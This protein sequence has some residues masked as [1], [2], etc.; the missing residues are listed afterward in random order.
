MPFERPLEVE[1][2]L[3]EAR[4]VKAVENWR[5]PRAMCWDHNKGTVSSGLVP[6]NRIR[7]DPERE[8]PSVARGFP[9][10]RLRNNVA[11]V[12]VKTLTSGL[13]VTR[14]QSSKSAMIGCELCFST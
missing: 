10:I 1:V 13:P 6:T 8:Q 3:V 4:W 7:G 9:G 2:A 11:R 5:V 14:A 12:C